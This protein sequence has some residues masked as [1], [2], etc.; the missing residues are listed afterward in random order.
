MSAE[1]FYR[2]MSAELGPFS[3]GEMQQFSQVGRIAPDTEVRKGQ[4]GTWVAAAQVKG[5]CDGQESSPG[6]PPRTPTAP[7]SLQATSV[8]GRVSDPYYQWLGIPPGEQPP[9]HYRLLGI[10]VFESSSD[11]ISNAAD[12]RMGYVR[13]F[14]AGEYSKLSQRI[15]NEISTARV[16]LLNPVKKVEYDSC[17]RQQL[18]DTVQPN[19]ATSHLPM[20]GPTKLDAERETSA[21]R[22]ETSSCLPTPGPT[23]LDAGCGTSGSRFETACHLPMP[24]L[25]E[26][27][28]HTS[29]AT[30]FR[31]RIKTLLALPR[32]I[33]GFLGSASG[34]KNSILH[35]LLRCITVVVVMGGLLAILVALDGVPHG[36]RAAR[37]RRDAKRNQKMSDGQP[38]IGVR[39]VPL[40]LEMAK[41]LRIKEDYG[42]LVGQIVPG[43]TA[44]ESGLKIGDIVTHLDE[45]RIRSVDEFTGG[46]ETVLKKGVG[47]TLTV[48]V[49]RDS[50]EMT[51]E[52]TAKSKPSQTYLERFNG[53][54]FAEV[55]Q[56]RGHQHS[57]TSVAFSP[58]G[59]FVV[60]G[61]RDTTARI[62][63]VE[64][65]KQLERFDHDGAVT[66][67]VVSS[68]GNLLV[69][70]SEDNSVRIWN[71]VD[72]QLLHKMEGHND[73]VRCVAISS[74]NRF[75][76]SGSEDGTV[77]VWD[78]HSGKLHRTFDGNK[79]AVSS[80]SVSPTGRNAVSTSIFSTIVWDFTTGKELTRLNPPNDVKGPVWAV[81]YS[82]D[83]RW[84]ATGH[85]KHAVI[86]NARSGDVMQI[87]RGHLDHVQAAAFT[88]DD[89]YLVTVSGDRTMRFWDLREDGRQIGLYPDVGCAKIFS[90][91]A[92]EVH[93]SP[94]GRYIATAWPGVHL[95]EMPPQA[96]IGVDKGSKDDHRGDTGYHR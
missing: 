47:A 18:E 33:D 61:S 64:T 43:S 35:N 92:Q 12:Q 34:E 46:L 2:S 57:V 89:R 69:T 60:S 76:L 20:P 40:S 53:K 54:G 23:K 75:V 25:T 90:L 68:D 94:S 4:N 50:Q 91:G 77:C 44:D 28:Q 11:V 59:S 55:R 87:L 16:C 96:R 27:D 88:P 85:K 80:L 7:Q 32:L 95:W 30:L 36:E 24:G 70:G 6:T 49:V 1:W 56:F 66:D 5:L 93:V 10:A 82:H 15:L 21:S 45:V 29:S 19:R 58:D 26:L 62:W 3:A 14:Q 79:Y 65:G 71:L 86:W 31:S 74:D 52:V 41:H 78:G 9:N 37:A 13:T 63:G 51:F 83:G 81:T 72:K 38:F 39:C 73:E 22:F 17:L 84:I 48:E 67:V 8:T 42:V